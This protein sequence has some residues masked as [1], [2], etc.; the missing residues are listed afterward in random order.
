MA[1]L[2]FSI[3]LAYFLIL[4]LFNKQDKPLIMYDD[5]E[6]N[7]SWKEWILGTLLITSILTVVLFTTNFSLSLH[8]IFGCMV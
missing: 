2:A 3:I 4:K 8:F 1:I 6:L 5:V 7:V